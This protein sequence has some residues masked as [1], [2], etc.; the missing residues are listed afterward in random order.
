MSYF[1]ADNNGFF[2][3]ELDREPISC[4]SVIK[5]ASNFAFLGSFIVDKT[6]RGK[7]YGLQTGKVALASL[8][9]S[10]NMGSNAVV[11][12]VPQYR[13]FGLEPYWEQQRFQFVASEVSKSLKYF[14]KTVEIIQPTQQVF[15]SLL[16][17]D[18]EIN[19][20]QRHSFLKNWVFAPNCHCSIAIDSL[21]KVVGYGVVRS[22]LREGDGWRIG[23]LYADNFA[24]AKTIFKSMCDKITMETR[25]AFVVIDIPYGL[26]FNK[27]SLSLVTECNGTSLE[28]FVRMYKYGI[29]ENMPL[30]KIFGITL[31]ALG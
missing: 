27:K 18:T 12:S 4:V 19:V 1:A 6:H 24:T 7:G 20:F 15:N 2:V 8:S 9:E 11:E 23:P 26:S 30:D 25:Q 29:P 16:K 31:L 10:C 14:N 3:G 17:Y 22:T 13:R 21:G 28:T 5:Y